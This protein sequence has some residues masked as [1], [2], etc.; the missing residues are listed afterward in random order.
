M[1]RSRVTAAILAILDA[2][3]FSWLPSPLRADPSYFEY[4]GTC[5][6]SA[7]V[8]LDADTFV[9]ANDED[10][11]LRIYRRGQAL[12][13]Q[14][15]DLN[16][17]L[18][19]GDKEADIEASA[20]IGNRIY[21]ST[22]HATNKKGKFRPAHHRIFATDIV[23]QGGVM[24]VVPAGRAYSGL[25]ADLVNAP[26]LRRY[27][28][29]EAA[30]LP[31]KEFG[32][33]NIEGMA[34]TPEG[35]LLLGFRNPIPDGKALIVPLENPAAIISGANAVLGQSIELALGGLG[36]RS[37]ERVGNEYLIVAG[38]YDNRSGFV[39]YKW[40][41]AASEPPIPVPDVKFRDFHPEALFAIPGTDMIQIL[42]DDGAKE[43]DEG[44]CKMLPESEQVFRSM[45]VKP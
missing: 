7:A 31:P 17:F 34:A 11:A 9:V 44:E 8:A 41:G 14:T 18:D 40:S 19:S 29:E 4:R 37:M 23:K 26:A 43:T 28:L 30:A 6:A 10:N 21:W 35:K 15:I 25:L 39:L 16:E 45:I 22:S 3:I 33:L 12:P 38:P 5:D 42:S 32:G 24:T 36:I 2:V 13:I 27:R 20:A 1:A